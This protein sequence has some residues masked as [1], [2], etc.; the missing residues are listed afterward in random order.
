MISFRLV[1]STILATL[2]RA[3]PGRVKERQILA[4]GCPEGSLRKTENLSLTLCP[5]RFLRDD[6][7]RK[8][9]AK[10]K[11]MLYDEDILPLEA[12][13]ILRPASDDLLRLAANG[14]IDLNRLARAEF[15]ARMEYQATLDIIA[16]QRGMS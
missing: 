5:P 2:K 1:S 6:V 12:H 3:V 7:L 11:T 13:E 4:F 16:L 10:G 15:R 14:Q 8:P 9:K